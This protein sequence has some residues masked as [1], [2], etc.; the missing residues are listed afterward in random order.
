MTEH[1]PGER[2]TKTESDLAASIKEAQA[3][4]LVPIIAEV[5][6][7]TP[8]LAEEGGQR[9]DVRDA[10]FLVQFYQNGGAI[11]ISLVAEEQ[12]FGGQPEIDIPQILTAVDLPLLIKDFITDRSKVDYYA[13]LVASVGE[14][15]LKR[16]SLLLI[17]H[18]LGDS[19]A[20]LIGYVHQRGM[21]AQ[22]EIQG[23][24][25]F[26]LLQ[27]LPRIPKLIGFN[28]KEIDRLEKGVDKV[29]LG[30][31]VVANCRQVIDSALLISSSAHHT[32][33]DVRQSINAGADA[34]LAGTAFMRA[35][36]PES[37]VKEFVNAFRKEEKIYV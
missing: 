13:D 18:K 10:G 23:E 6:R 1:K 36:N 37:V 14:E 3:C 26:P 2:I 35:E 15:M 33:E 8:K 11:G 20:G 29:V 34:V 4:G 22:V 24:Q 5:K 9:K 28:N 19:L 32:P 12:H 16:V 30:E 27:A 31:S 7:L 25:D 21:L 17:S